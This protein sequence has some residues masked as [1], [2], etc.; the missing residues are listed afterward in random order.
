MRVAAIGEPAQA[1]P[2]SQPARGCRMIPPELQQI[3]Q[4]V[5]WKYEKARAGGKAAEDSS[6]SAHRT[7]GESEQPGRPG[8]IIQRHRRRWKRTGWRAWD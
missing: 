4:W 1:L 6:K 7:R 8:R 5:G 2:L 3:P